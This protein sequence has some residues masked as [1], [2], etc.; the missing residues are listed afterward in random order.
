MT[1]ADWITAYHEFSDDELAQ[2]I[3]RLNEQRKNVMVSQTVGSKSYTRSLESINMQ[4][5]AAMSVRR[6]RRLTRAG[7]GRNP[8]VGFS[9]FSDIRVD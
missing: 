5:A 4:F 9:D 7:G 3:D 6:E 1:S 2:E 8:A